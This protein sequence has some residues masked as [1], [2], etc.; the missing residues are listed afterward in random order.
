MDASFFNQFGITQETIGQISSTWELTQ[1]SYPEHGLYFLE[2]EYLLDIVAQSGLHA[3]AV[4]TLL[5][6]AAK[7]RQSDALSRLAWHC[8]WMLHIATPELKKQGAPFTFEPCGCTFFSVIVTAAAMPELRAFYKS[9]GIPL[10][11]LRDSA[12]VIDIWAQDYFEKN[13]RWGVSCPWINETFSHNLFRLNRLEFQFSAYKSPF[14]IFKNTT[15]GDTCALAPAGCEIAAD[16]FF[17]QP[18]QATA[19]STTLTET[20]ASITGHPALPNGRLSSQTVTLPFNEWQEL[21]KPGAPMVEVHIPAIA[22]LTYEACKDSME[23]ARVFFPKYFPEFNYQGFMT[24]S[25][26]LDPTLQEMLP[27]TSNIVRFQSLFHLYPVAG[28]DAWQ[29]RER[30]FGNP[31]LPMDKVPQKTSLQRIVHDKILAGHRFRGESCYA[32]K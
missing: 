15:T 20:A 19:F 29:I 18:D 23:Q 2:E 5:A 16:G 30:V 13:G 8:H 25:W 31:D 26:L 17:R 9:R 14:R 32:L 4:P 24:T 12:T 11:I 3:E 7:I 10:S 21:F 27:P 22:P 28:A 6:D 1:Q